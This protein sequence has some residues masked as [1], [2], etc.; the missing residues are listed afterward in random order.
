M[1]ARDGVGRGGKGGEEREERE[2]WGETQ[3]AIDLQKQESVRQKERREC[4]P[5]ILWVTVQQCCK[6]NHVP[7]K[8]MGRLVDPPPNGEQGKRREMVKL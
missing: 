8:E 7:S 5:L 2:A 3:R 1:E 4:F 6:L